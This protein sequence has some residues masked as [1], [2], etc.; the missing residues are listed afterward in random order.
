M[1]NHRRHK[2]VPITGTVTLTFKDKNEFR[3]IQAL[4]CS[5]SLGGIGL[6]ADEPIEDDTS[7]SITIN[8]LSFDGIK[9][10]SIEGRVVYS[11]NIGDIDF[12]GIQFKEEI[13]SENQNLLYEHMQKILASDK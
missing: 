1:I 7:I 11:R 13:N 3:S 6:Y 4:L 5:I 9:T 10:E 12:M 8:F 2:R